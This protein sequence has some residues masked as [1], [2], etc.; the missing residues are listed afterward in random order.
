MDV[1]SE[2]SSA[3][4]LIKQGAEARIYAADFLGRPTIVKER[5]KKK[6]RH[7]VLDDKL[8]HKRT[9]QEV[10]SMHRCRKAG[11]ATPTVFF[12]D[13]NDYKI[14]MEEVQNSITVRDYINSLKED[15]ESNLR[16]LAKIIG[17]ILASMHNIQVIHGDLTTSNM[18]LKKTNDIEIADLVLID[19]GLSSISS[20]AEDKGV[21]LYVLERAFLSTHPNTEDAFKVIL[22]TYKTFKGS[23]EAL[24]K[25]DEVRL[26]GRKRT[27]VG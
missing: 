11:I 23:S 1:E 4:R 2:G 7:N 10:R 16:K 27:M 18:L 26:R 6:F 19:F 5:F 24:K 22:D 8:R 21:D 15:K 20:L 12:I 13:S 17:T 25:L 9:M 14:Y 3:L